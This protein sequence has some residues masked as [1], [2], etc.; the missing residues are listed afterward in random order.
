MFRYV[1]LE[2]G[3]VAG[4]ALMT[5]GVAG[6]AASV[7]YWSTRSFGALDPTL[8]LRAV[9]PSAVAIA[10]GTQVILASFFLSVLGLR[11]RRQ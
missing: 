5:V 4:A 6:A 3:L 9:V 10:L 8:V 1:T 7:W 2:T 11:V